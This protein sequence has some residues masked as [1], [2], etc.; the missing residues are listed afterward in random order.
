[1]ELSGV[2]AL[3]TGGASGL[4]EATVRA[5]A[6]KGAVVTVVDR[7][8]ERGK[9]L[10]AELDGARFAECD[11]TD[12]E[13]VADAVATAADGTALRVVANCA[14]VGAGMRTI[15]K[16]G[17]PHNRKVFDRVVRV[18][19]MGTFQVMSHAAAAMAQTTP[20]ADELRGVIINTASVAAFDGQVGQLAY[21]ASKGGVVGMTLPAAR[22]LATI[23]VRVCTIAPG[24]FDTPMM[25]SA[26][27]KVRQS[28]SATVVAPHRLGHPNEYAKLAV[29]I[30]ENDYLNGEVIRLD[31]AIR[32][33]PR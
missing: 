5:L 7:D 15:D 10:I 17:N 20:D 28:L 26:T 2:G 25:A 24:L 33:Q 14:G 11:V 6:A 1:M 21:S 30:A 22:D 19:L 23:G 12:D 13:Q 8:V 18:N 31:G 9:A 3:V 4:G 29:A 16:D 32:L 27:D